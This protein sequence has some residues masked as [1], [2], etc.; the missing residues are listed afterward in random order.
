MWGER[1]PLGSALLPRRAAGSGLIGYLRTGEVVWLCGVQRLVGVFLKV[2]LGKAAL[3]VVFFWDLLAGAV[4]IS[5]LGHFC[6]L[7]EE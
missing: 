4:V 7:S 6:V 5:R 1:A 3:G 2:R